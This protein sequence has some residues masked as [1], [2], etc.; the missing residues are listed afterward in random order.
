MWAARRASSSAVSAAAHASDVR[1]SRAA[2]HASTRAAF[3]SASDA[4]RSAKRS[5][6]STARRLRSSCSRPRL[7]RG[8]GRDHFPNCYSV[9]FAGGG[10]RGGQV[11]GRSDRIASTPADQA[12]GPA[13][14]HATVFHALGISPESQIQDA[15]GRPLALTDGRPLPLF[16]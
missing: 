2:S 4:V 7:N 6:T 13:D 10:V 15:F 1:S 9:A 8:A 12:C 16:G 3:S 11:Y 14:L 5:A